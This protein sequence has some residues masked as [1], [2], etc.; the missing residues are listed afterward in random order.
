MTG[1]CRYSL[2]G[3][4][5]GWDAVLAPAANGGAPKGLGATGRPD[6]SRA[7]QLLGLPQISLPVATDALGLPLGLQVIG[8][9]GQDAALLTTAR[10]LQE[11]MGWRAVPPTMAELSR[12]VS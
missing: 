5:L 1:F 4:L 6:Q 7:W 3:A 2:D 9:Y 10:V 12:K 8:R 11:R